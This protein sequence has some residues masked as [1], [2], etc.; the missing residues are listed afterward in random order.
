MPEQEL[1]DSP[2]QKGNEEEGIS[3]VFGTKKL[4]K[5]KYA[6]SKFE[7]TRQ[8]AFRTL[9]PRGYIRRPKVPKW[10]HQIIDLRTEKWKIEETLV[11]FN[12]F[13]S[14]TYVLRIF[15]QLSLEYAKHVHTNK[16][17]DDI[18]KDFKVKFRGDIEREVEKILSTYDPQM[19][20]SQETISHRSA[21][22]KSIESL[23]KSSNVESDVICDLFT[24]ISE[25]ISKIKAKDPID[26]PTI[27]PFYDRIRKENTNFI[28][29]QIEQKKKDYIE[30]NAEQL[31]ARADK[32]L[33][34]DKLQKQTLDDLDDKN[35]FE[36]EKKEKEKKGIEKQTELDTN[37]QIFQEKEKNRLQTEL[38]I[39]DTADMKH[40]NALIQKEIEKG[41][42][43]NKLELLKEQG[44]QAIREIELEYE[45]QK[46]LGENI[47]E[48]EKLNKLIEMFPQILKE[49]NK[50]PQSI[51]QL[52]VI[53][54][55]SQDKTGD[56]NSV[57]DSVIGPTVQIAQSMQVLKEMMKLLNE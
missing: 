2:I 35:E 33:V 1:N 4:P 15:F 10:Y 41:E 34:S 38:T 49:L 28:I 12:G 36:K 44:K 3:K 46:K 53:Q 13:Y 29:H 39:S 5:P 24:D 47:I 14:I 42:H 57:A 11:F 48:T 37:L 45:K 6:H 7:P 30:I 51:D 22:K 43:E 18:R 21:I 40:D 9:Y 25:A 23:L 32:K 55:H 17:V 19:S 50:N 16:L 52:R 8:I 20:L 26:D 54:V 27:E 31:K 56:K